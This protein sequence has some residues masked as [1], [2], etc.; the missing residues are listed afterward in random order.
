M[1][2]NIKD[3]MNMSPEEFDTVEELSRTRV[4]RK[5]IKS[6]WQCIEDGVNT[7]NSKS[8]SKYRKW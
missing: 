7:H 8:V 4:S 3:V 6:N 5:E 2:V 1:K